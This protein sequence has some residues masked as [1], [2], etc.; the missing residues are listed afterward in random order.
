M[1]TRWSRA[2]ALAGALLVIA[3]LV[4]VA[5]VKMIAAAFEPGTPPA[6]AD[7]LGT[8]CSPEG[9]RLVLTDGHVTVDPMSPVLAGQISYRVPTPKPGTAPAATT[10]AGDW[11]VSVLGADAMSGQ[12][13]TLA[14]QVEEIGRDTVLSEMLEFDVYER[15]AG[16][17]FSLPLKPAGSGDLAFGKC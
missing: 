9:D 17:A 2:L 1:P 15:D 4:V 8:W 13:V 10:A 12:V 6:E 7:F 11:G 14:V 3:L 16:W 5:G